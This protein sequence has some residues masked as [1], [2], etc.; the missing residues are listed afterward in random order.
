MM[1][2]SP[3]SCWIFISSSSTWAW[4]VT[5][6]AVVGSSAMIRSGSQESASAIMARCRMP[7]EN[8][9]GCSRARRAGSGMPT[10]PSTSTARFSAALRVPPWC[11]RYASAIWSP[12]VKY[13]CREVSASWKI[14]AIRRPRSL[15]TV[16]SGA[17]SSS[18]PSKRTEPVTSAPRC[19]P[20]TASE[21][22]DLPEPDSPTIPS[23]RP[24]S[25]LKPTPLTARTKPSGVLN[26]TARS[27]TSSS[28][29]TASPWGRSRR[30]RGPRPGW[31]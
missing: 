2:P 26:S 21:V 29:M 25:T 5:S 18:A 6:S 14:I 30:R 27:L 24:R 16:S 15:R 17:P 11:S 13:G 19:R 7:P 31:N 22:T 28:V 8:W 1:M 9:C 12:M 3:R 10:S 4:T 20:I 23:V